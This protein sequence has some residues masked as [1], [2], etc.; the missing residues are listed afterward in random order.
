[1]SR[2]AKFLFIFSF[3]VIPTISIYSLADSEVTRIP[4]ID[5]PPGTVGLGFGFR[6]STNPYLEGDQ[7]SE[8]EQETQLDLV[9][10]YLFEGKHLFAHGTSFGVHMY[11]NE[12]FMADLLARYRFDRLDPDSNAYFDGLQK[13]EQTID[14]GLSLIYKGDFGSVKFDWVTD[15]MNT[16]KGMELDFTYR[17]RFDIGRWMVSPFISY[18]YQDATLTNYYYGVSQDEARPGRPAHKTESAEFIRAGVNTSYQLTKRWLLYTNIAFEGLDESIVESPLTEE[19]RITSFMLGASYMFGD[20]YRADDVDFDRV[21]E[22]S[23]RINYGY[24]ADGSI[25]TDNIKG[26]LSKSD[27]V[28]D[29]G[30]AGITISKLILGGPRVDA[31]AR[32]AVFRHLE[33]DYQDDFWNYTPYVMLIGK[34]YI[35]WSNQLKFR[36]G[37][38]LGV[39]YAEQIPAIEQVKQAKKD[40]TSSHLLNYLEWTLD[41]PVNQIFDSKAFR[42]C[43][44]GIT[45]VHRSGIFASADILNNV[46]GGADWLTLH[47]EC[48]R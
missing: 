25:A 16:H 15:L 24:T 7:S 41:F 30:I 27:D 31:Y 32:F 34:G 28:S 26:D 47:L 35:P 29:T 4:I 13:R 43:F 9:P 3:I 17:Y 19:E 33:G 46:D 44:I 40:A 39:S 45:D 22:W 48:L 1:M 10:M 38:G 12:H 2:I 36:W 5:A 42:N 21:S 14:G 37:F 23:W 8:L 6:L 18:I 11:K 20:I